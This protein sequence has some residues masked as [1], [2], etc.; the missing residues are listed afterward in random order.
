[1]SRVPGNVIKFRVALQLHPSFPDSYI[2]LRFPEQG[3][4]FIVNLFA[5][6]ERVRDK[7]FQCCLFSFI[8]TCF[9]LPKQSIRY[10]H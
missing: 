5:I 2:V 4:K 10:A 7:A 3:F 1:M 6:S 8:T 9:S